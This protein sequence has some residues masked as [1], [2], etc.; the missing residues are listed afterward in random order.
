[1]GCWMSFSD[2]GMKSSSFKKREWGEILGD[3]ETE[4]RYNITDA[5]L[6]R[7][8]FAA[9]LS[10]RGFWDTLKR[11]NFGNRRP[12]EI[13]VLNENREEILRLKRP[14]YWFFSSMEVSSQGEVLGSIHRRRTFLSKYGGPKTFSFF[15]PR[16]E[17]TGQISKK[18]SGLL[19]EAISDADKFSIKFIG[20]WASADKALLLA[21]AFTIDMDCFED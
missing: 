21:S 5:A 6:H 9:E 19:T 15:N 11:Q 8:G 3:Y 4:N 10:G 14:F 17:T 7:I 16:G 2:P 18:W 12:M 13:V 1:M 20:D